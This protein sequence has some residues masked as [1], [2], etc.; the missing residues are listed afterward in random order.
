MKLLNK[1]RFVCCGT[2]SLV[3]YKT[4]YMCVLCP[5]PT[6]FPAGIWIPVG[7]VAIAGGMVGKKER[8]LRS[9]IDVRSRWCAI[10]ARTGH[11]Y[12]SASRSEALHPVY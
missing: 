2:M 9:S 5:T 12:S 1:E 4:G 6:G 11:C 10:F 8:S 7:L 3:G